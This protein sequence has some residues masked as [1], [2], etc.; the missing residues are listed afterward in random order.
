[1]VIEVVE[2]LFLFFC[3][4]LFVYYSSNKSIRVVNEFFRQNQIEVIEIKSKWKGRDPFIMGRSLTQPW[5]YVKLRNNDGEI[6]QAYVKVGHW[7]F[8]ILRPIVQVYPVDKKG[9]LI[10]KSNLQNY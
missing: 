8:G 4:Y 3:L 10:E 2:I 1:M 6:A 5:Y 7:F 9:K